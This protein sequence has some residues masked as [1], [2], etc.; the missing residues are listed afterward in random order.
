[1]EGA[2]RVVRGEEPARTYRPAPHRG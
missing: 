1:V 2:L